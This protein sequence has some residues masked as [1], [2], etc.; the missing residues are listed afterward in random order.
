[1]SDAQAIAV[2]EASI[3]N[4]VVE[5]VDLQDFLNYTAYSGFDRSKIVQ[6]LSSKKA[7]A[8]DIMKMILLVVRLGN[9]PFAR[10]RETSGKKALTK[11][12]QSKQELQ[13]M[14][15]RFALADAGAQRE[16]FITIGS[17]AAAFPL[18]SIKIWVEIYSK[19]GVV[20]STILNNIDI[21]IGNPW[22]PAVVSEEQWKRTSATW[23]TWANAQTFAFTQGK[24]LVT[25]ARILV[26]M[27]AKTMDLNLYSSGCAY[28]DQ[29]LIVDGAALS[30]FKA[31]PVYRN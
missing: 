28:V 8:G 4:F 21:A 12:S 5:K 16:G 18:F 9:K 31:N 3:S 7:L 27:R 6:H 17:I 15:A 29:V 10:M 2:M 11:P 13:N 30:A 26:A 20:P 22:Y 19:P 14:E 24:V 23:I 1:M 25:D